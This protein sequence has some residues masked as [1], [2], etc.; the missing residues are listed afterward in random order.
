MSPFQCQSKL[1][2]ALCALLALLSAC[3]QAERESAYPDRPRL[4]SNVVMRDITFHSASLNREMPYRVVMPASIPAGVKFPVV[5]LLHGGSGNFRDWTNYS[6]VARFAER[7]LILVMPD[8]DESYYTN[9]ADHP[10]RRYEDYIIKDLIADVEARFPVA[11]DRAHR[12][13]AGLSMG[14]FGAIKLSLKHPELFSFSAG[15]SSAIDVPTRPF[16]IRRVGQWRHHRSIFGPPGAAV[17]RANDPFELAKSADPAQ[18]P[19]FYLT[20]GDAEGLLPSNRSFAH[21]L[22][23]RHFAYEF[24][25][26]H[27][28]HNWNQWNARLGDCFDSLLKHL[29]TTS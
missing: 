27:G 15:L 9:S 28:G 10:E 12:A 25:V 7:G 17:R 19:Y 24:H 4:T 1:A 16:S 2:V 20:C 11:S 5:Y 23:E 8:G 18:V 14:G 29:G 13:I 26:V 21:L 6:D 3:R 22:E